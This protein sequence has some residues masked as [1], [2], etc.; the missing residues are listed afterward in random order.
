MKT[1]STLDPSS[2][3]V[4]VVRTKILCSTQVVYSAWVRDDSGPLGNGAPSFG[5]L[6][7]VGGAR[8]GRLGTEDLPAEL[9]VLR[10]SVRSERVRPW[11]RERNAAAISAIRAAGVEGDPDVTMGE[12]VAWEVA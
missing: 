5:S 7:Y 12:V 11:Q 4:Q 1:L 6:T 8:F 10:G 2:S 3:A 9:D